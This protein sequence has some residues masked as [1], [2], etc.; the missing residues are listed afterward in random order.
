M[1]ARRR[2]ELEKGMGVEAVDHLVVADKASQS[3][4]QSKIVA[5]GP[6][7]AK[8][9]ATRSLDML[10]CC[11][12]QQGGRGRPWGSWESPSACVTIVALCRSL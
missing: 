3:E 7:V 9:E 4:E 12:V 2:D 1:A 8:H 5:S 6:A 11:T 10:L